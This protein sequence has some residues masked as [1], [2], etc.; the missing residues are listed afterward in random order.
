MIL[1][2]STKGYCI[3]KMNRI[4]LT[5]CSGYIGRALVPNLK[6]KGYFVL[7][8][9]RKPYP[10]ADLDDFIQGDLLD[11]ALLRRS[12]DSIDTVIHLAAAKDDWG[13]SD[14]EYFR[15]NVAV[16]RELLH[17]VGAKG[18]RHWVFFSSVAVLGSGSSPLNEAAPIAPVGAY[19]QSKAQ[20]E[21]LFRQFADEETS[22]QSLIIRPSVVFGPENPSNTNIFRLI[23][24]IYRNRFVM[25]GKGDVIKTTSYLENLIAA[26]LFL[27]EKMQQG[28]NTFIYVDEPKLSTADIVQQICC[29]LQKSPPK[30]HIPRAIATPL[31]YLADIAAAVTRRDLPITAARIQKF[32][33]ATN[34]DARAVREMGFEQPVSIE[35]GLRRTVQWY[36]HVR[37]SQ[38]R[39]EEQR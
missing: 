8:F 9:D 19:G 27:I 17:G 18:I 2:R 36:L 14:E 10:K 6:Q 20:A 24:A 4:L 35:E 34:F 33:R 26:T 16:T 11:Q 31:A 13:I 23:D 29:L 38:G 37:D 12:L 1:S 21:A 32:C 5:G 30:W 15:D 22:V 25:I 3:P 7:G 39:T 28:V